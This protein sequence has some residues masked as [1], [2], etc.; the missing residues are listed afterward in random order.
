MIIN[1]I[2]TIGGFGSRMKPISHLEKY[3]LYYLNKSI[4]AHILDIFPNAQVVGKTKTNS[5]KETL[6]QINILNNVL[7]IDCDIIPFKI[8]IQ[9]IDI[10]QNNIYAFISNK[11][12]YGSIIVDNN[13]VIKSDERINISNVKC[14]GVYFCKDLSSVIKN[15]TDD[16]SII[17]G[18]IGSKVIMEDTFKRFGDIE[19]YY[20]TIGL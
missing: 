8:N 2:I 15:M 12:K 3:E 17:S 14:S 16:N 7:I 5:R 9:D 19:D 10:Y 1:P 13:Y 4:L 20:E 18:M 6:Q 11:P